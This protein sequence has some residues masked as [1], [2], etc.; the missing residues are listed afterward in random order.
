YDASYDVWGPTVQLEDQIVISGLASAG[1]DSGALLLDENKNIVGLFWGGSDTHAIGSPI[2][3]ILSELN[4]RFELTPVPA[5]ST[6]TSTTTTLAPIHMRGL[7]IT[8]LGEVTAALKGDELLVLVSDPSRV[9][10]NKKIVVGGA[11]LVSAFP[12]RGQVMFTMPGTLVVGDDQAPW[13]I[14]GVPAG[15]TLTG[16]ALAVKTAPSSSSIRVDIQHS[17]NCGLNWASIY[18]I[19]PSISS[20]NRCGTGGSLSTTYIEQGSILRLD[21]DQVGS[22]VAG[23]DLTVSLRV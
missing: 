7:E 1:G 16:T 11:Y 14:C 22:S 6:S 13:F 17:G 5:T 20:G 10:I 12:I 21:I 18:S 19:R 23:A 15:L 3:A 9:P 2:G 8:E 4:I